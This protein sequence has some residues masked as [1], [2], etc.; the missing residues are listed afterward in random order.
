MNTNCAPCWARP[1]PSCGG[2][3][4]YCWQQISDGRRQIR[5]SCARC[6]KWLGFAAVR[7]PYTTAADAAASAT[8]LLDALAAAR[9]PML[10]GL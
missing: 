4:A 9:A 6:A 10:P 7:P 2:Q 5:A 8:P 1:C 3:A